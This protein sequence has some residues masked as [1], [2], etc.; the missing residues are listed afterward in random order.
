MIVHRLDM[1]TSGCVIMARSDAGL[2][3]LNRQVNKPRGCNYYREF[4]CVAGCVCITL[5]TT[6][7]LG[8][9]AVAPFSHVTS[10]DWLG[11]LFVVGPFLYLCLF[12]R[13]LFGFAPSSVGIAYVLPSSWCVLNSFESAKCVNVTLR[14]CTAFSRRTK[15]RSISPCVETGLAPLYT[16]STTS[17]ES[18]R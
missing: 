1:A 12:L 4:R 18:H 15:E 16:W 6:I 13:S 14:W 10:S 8:F 11:H 5:S 9:S 17:T 3:D 2:K 7:V